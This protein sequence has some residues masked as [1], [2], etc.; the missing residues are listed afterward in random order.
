MPTLKPPPRYPSADQFPT[1]AQHVRGGTKI[2]VARP[3]IYTFKDGSQ[4]RYDPGEYLVS[5]EM[6]ANPWVHRDFGDGRISHINGKPVHSPLAGP[7]SDHTIEARRA[8][9]QRRDV[10]VTAMEKMNNPVRVGLHREPG[11]FPPHQHDLIKWNENHWV[12]RICQHLVKDNGME[13]GQS[14]SPMKAPLA[15]TPK[16]NDG[17][18]NLVNEVNVVQKGYPVF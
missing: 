17:S 16:S 15:E 1:A 2:Q 12:C 3:F 18:L 11:D 13:M 8:L 14:A 7:V 5:E 10:L 9:E 6:M 4:R